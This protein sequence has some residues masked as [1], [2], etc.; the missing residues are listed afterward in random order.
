MIRRLTYLKSEYPTQFWLLFW[1]YLISTIGASMIW[2]FLM[3]YVSE[4]LQMPL[5]T[6]ASLMTINAATG[7]IFSF[8][9]GSLIDRLGR[10]W[11]MVISLVVNGIGYILLNNASTLEAYAM[12]MAISGAF[13][14]LYRI[15]ADAMMA[16]LIPPKKRLDAYS[17]LRM[18]HNVGVA[19]GP[20]IGGFIA[21]RSYSITFAIAAAGMLCYALLLSIFA[22][23]TLPQTHRDDVREKDKPGGYGQVLRDKPFMFFSAT[24]V[25]TQMC[26][27]IMWVLLAVYAKQNYQVPESQYGLIPTTNAVMVVLFQLMVTQVTKRYPPL[28]VLASGSFLYGLAVGSVALGQGFWAFLGSMIIM[29]VGELILI[30]TATTLT[31]NLSPKDMRGRYMSIYGLTWGIASGIGPVIGGL[32]NDNIGP[33]A[34]WHGGFVIGMIATASFFGLGVQYSKTIT[35]SM[36]IAG[37]PE[38]IELPVPPAN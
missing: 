18:G 23:E 14:P 1:G 3:I 33:T 26:S 35:S 20:A 17:L 15:G 22:K 29:T 31:A 37:D 16:D 11:I 8:I 4:R 38:E 24:F 10:K 5:T 9:G 32:L 13:N 2:P 30:P 36:G 7:L 34:I 28:F 12:L 25:L 21:T 6:T 27:A 19:L